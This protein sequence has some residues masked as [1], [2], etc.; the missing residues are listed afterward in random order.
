[1]C[2]CVLAYASAVDNDRRTA[3]AS[4]IYETQL[5]SFTPPFTCK[6]Y[7]FA[8]MAISD[9]DLCLSSPSSSSEMQID[10]SY[11]QGSSSRV[12]SSCLREAMLKQD[13]S[14]PESFPGVVDAQLMDEEAPEVHYSCLIYQNSI[15]SLSIDIN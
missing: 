11:K 14:D 8:K 5:L 12:L 10:I 9:V 4:Y 2:E 3:A 13:G 15:L 6:L 7:A 1:M